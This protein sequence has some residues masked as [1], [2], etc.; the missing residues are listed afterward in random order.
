MNVLLRTFT[1]LFGHWESARERGRRLL[2]AHLTP[3]QRK[4]YDIHGH[5]DVVGGETGHRYRIRQGDALN[6]EEYD[7]NGTYLS[8]WCFSPVGNLVLGDILLAQKL[9][10]ELFESD[11]RALANRYPTDYP[12]SPYRGVILRR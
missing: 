1:R 9:A 7:R 10:L 11:T 2:L 5:F 3:I 12:R 4:Q 6:I 8:R